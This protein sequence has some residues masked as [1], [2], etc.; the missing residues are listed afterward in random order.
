MGAP[1]PPPGPTCVGKF[2]NITCADYSHS[3]CGDEDTITP[4]CVDMTKG[5]CCLDSASH[6]VTQCSFTQVCQGTYCAD[7][8]LSEEPTPD[9]APAPAPPT[10]PTCV[11]KFGNVTCPDYSHSCCGDDDTMTPI[12][13][14]MTKG[15]CCL[16]PASHLVNVCSFTQTCIGTYCADTLLGD[17][18]VP[19]PTPAPTPAPPS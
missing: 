3:C 10:G 17:E 1:A 5:T 15:T 4:I 13:V 18:P 12:C 11:G 14:D 19:D 2:G 7:A 8:S 16:D 9:P 6:L